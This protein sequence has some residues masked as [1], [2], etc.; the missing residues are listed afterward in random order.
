MMKFSKTVMISKVDDEIVLMDT[1]QEST[2]LGEY[3]GLNSIGTKMIEMLFEH[4]DMDT[5]VSIMAETH[6]APEKQI[7]ADLE[8]L[9]RELRERGLLVGKGKVGK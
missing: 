7:W 8:N 9:V 3:Y 4:Q 2:C 5:T 1:G 6:D